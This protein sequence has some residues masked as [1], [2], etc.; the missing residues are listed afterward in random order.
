MIKTRGMKVNEGLNPNGISWKFQ[1]K[2]SLKEVIDRRK[3][4]DVSSAVRL[5]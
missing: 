2:G 3:E 1:K 4:G 5:E